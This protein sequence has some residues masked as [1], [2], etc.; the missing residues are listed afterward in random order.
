[1]IRDS[2]PRFEGAEAQ[3]LG[4]SVDS[5]ESHKDFAEKYGLPFPLLSDEHKEVVERYGVR[6]GGRTKRTSFLIGTDGV[7]EKV[8]ENVNPETHA[9]EV[10]ED[11]RVP[12]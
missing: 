11:L 2:F 3:I 1:M 7:V 10:L 8:Y 9:E 6:E 5:V 12:S 4:V